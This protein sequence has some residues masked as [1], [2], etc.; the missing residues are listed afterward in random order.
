[1]SARSVTARA[2][3]AE[4]PHSS[5]IRTAILEG[6]GLARFLAHAGPRQLLFEFLGY[7]GL[8]IGEALG[9]TWADIDYAPRRR[10]DAATT[11]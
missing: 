3:T 6:D 9:L 5:H 11:R 10:R 4:K 1:M 8:R 7:A 2:R